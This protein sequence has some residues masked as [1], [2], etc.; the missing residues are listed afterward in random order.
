MLQLI[1]HPNLPTSTKLPQN[2]HP[3]DKRPIRSALPYKDIITEEK[4]TGFVFQN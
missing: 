1:N 4:Q 2:Y 3:C